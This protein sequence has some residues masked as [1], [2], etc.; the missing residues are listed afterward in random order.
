MSLLDFRFAQKVRQV[1][2]DNTDNMYGLKSM[3]E[4]SAVDYAQVEDQVTFIDNH[5]MERFHTS[6]ANRR[7]LEQA[8]ALTLTSRGVPAS[9]MEQSSTWRA[10]T[11]L[12]IGHGSLHSPP[13]QPLIK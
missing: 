2:R 5:D 11:I 7:K 10:A 3:L 8:L 6:S 9:I 13:R 12:T 1:L 4:G